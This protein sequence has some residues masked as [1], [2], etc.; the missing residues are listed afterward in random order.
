MASLFSHVSNFFKASDFAKQYGKDHE[1]PLQIV[2]VELGEVGASKEIKPIVTFKDEPRRIVLN[3]TNYETLI[4]AT[5]TDDVDAYAGLD[6]L[7]VYNG[8]V[9]YSGNKGGLRFKMPKKTKGGK[10]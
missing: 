1:L 5:G 7:L 6:I 9:S 8:E 4:E 3:K 2:K 10:S